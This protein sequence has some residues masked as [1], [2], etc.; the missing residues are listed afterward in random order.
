M[1]LNKKHKKL[2]NE[3]GIRLGTQHIARYNWA[4]EEIIA[5]SQL[6]HYIFLGD[7]Y[8]DEILKIRSWLIQ[9][10]IP[11]FEYSGIIIE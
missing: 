5:L 3:S 6:L 11:C 8:K 4:E 1:S 10:K 9:R 7:K 2:F